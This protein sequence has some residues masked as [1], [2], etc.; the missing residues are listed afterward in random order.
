MY[1]MDLAGGDVTFYRDLFGWQPEAAGVFTVDGQVVAGHGARGRSGWNVHTVVDDVPATCRAAREHGGEVL[2]GPRSSSLGTLATLA[3]PTGG[4]FVV[5]EPGKRA[6]A[7]HRPLA[8]CWAELCTV[9]AQAARS[10]YQKLF[11][12][13]TVDIMMAMPAAE[14]GYTVFLAGEEEAAG[15]LPAGGA[16]GPLKPPYWLPYV[17]AD[18]TDKLAAHAEEL[19]G[20]VLAEPFDIPR[21]GRVALLSGRGGEVFAL[22]QM[23]DGAGHE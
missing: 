7:L 11:N 1:W 15:L 23:P 5:R 12:W 13:S 6:D 17:E 4:V 16:F 10:F 21:I 3:D 22:M 18:D 14:V 9:D 19:G 20:T 8:F 2:A